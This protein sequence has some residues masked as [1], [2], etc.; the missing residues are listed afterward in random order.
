[1]RM[2]GRTGASRD[3]SAGAAVDFELFMARILNEVLPDLQ[4][5]T[6]P[7]CIIL[8]RKF[9]STGLRSWPSARLHQQKKKGA[10][11]SSTLV[12][13]VFEKGFAAPASITELRLTL[14]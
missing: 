8:S 14:G 9:S 10:G 2:R 7:A 3:G 4:A 1:M 13:L 12:N 5:T 6:N 11:K